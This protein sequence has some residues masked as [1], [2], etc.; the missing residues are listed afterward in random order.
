MSRN[1]LHKHIY[2]SGNSYSIVKSV[3]GK[4][5]YYKTCRTIHE[6]M[7]YRDRLIENNWQPI[8]D[9]EREAERYFRYLHLH[10]KRRYYA[11][12]NR[13][14]EY[15]G[16]TRTIE[17]ALWYRDRYVNTAKADAPPV[18]TLD[19]KTDNPYYANGLK[20]PIPDRLKIPERNSSY[21][22]GRIIEKGP[23]SFHVHHGSKPSFVCSCPTPEMAEYVRREMNKVGWDRTQLQRILDDYPKY[24]T[25]L[26]FFYQYVNR[27]VYKGKQYGWSVVFPKEY[28]DG[29]I[30]KMIYSDIR[31]ALFERDFLKEHGWDY[32]L[33]VECIDDTNNPYE[34]ME[35]PPYPTRKIRNIRERNYHEKELLEAAEYVR[36]GF[37][38][39][40]IA[41]RLGVTDVT[42][43]NWLKKDWNATFKE[44]KEIVLAGENPLEVM[45]KQDIIFQ[46]DLSRTQPPNFNNYVHYLQRTRTWSVSNGD[47]FFGTYPTEELAQKISN[48]LQKCNWDKSKLKEI[49]KKHG[50]QSKI[51]SRNWVYRQSNG[52]WMVRRKDKNGK[53]IY[54][55]YWKDKRT[56]EMVRD[57]LLLYGFKVENRGWVVEIAEW[58]RQMELLLPNTMFGRVTVDD[59][60]YLE[61]DNVPEHLLKTTSGKYQV[62]KYINGK[63]ITYGSYPKDRAVRVVEFLKD[64][65]WDKEL[66]ET[67]QTV[68]EI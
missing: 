55:G 12:T 49:Q 5:I 25:M 64:N 48:D 24:Y 56:A 32:D 4:R 33:L 52:G 45:E 68:G 38:H 19:L 35:L 16:M 30:E 10:S 43:R 11:V 65:N 28:T 26:Q 9:E 31:T 29:K 21:G 54:Y 59:L 62:R 27:N 6:A 20:Y 50:H 60:A 67:M 40:E 15:L 66:L 46:P 1:P 53:S 34:D 42:L 39:G 3:K 8:D 22:V 36:E 7:E 57:M 44:F 23:T 41:D 58:T 17:E 61:Q 18:R 37:S 14:D 63:I 51:G 2:K 13:W 47:Q